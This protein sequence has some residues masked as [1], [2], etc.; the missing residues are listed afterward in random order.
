M[1]FYQKFLSFLKISQQFVF[2]VQKREKINAG[3]VKS[4][5]LKNMLKYSIFRNFIKNSWKISKISK[6]I[7]TP[8]VLRPNERK[9]NAGFVNIIEKE[10]KIT[11]FC[12]F[13]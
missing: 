3:C 1:N 12:Y 11:H 2:L 6:Y 4:L 10:A 7:Q 8:C 9:S 13:I 5:F